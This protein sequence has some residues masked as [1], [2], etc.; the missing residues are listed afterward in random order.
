[1]SLRRINFRQNTFVNACAALVFIFAV[2][3]VAAV[4]PA[5]AQNVEAVQVQ[6]ASWFT[7]R[8]G[9][10]WG[11]ERPMA[12]RCGARMDHVVERMDDHA[13]DEVT[14]T[15]AEETAWLGLLEAVRQS[16]A[17][18]QVFCSKLDE[19]RTDDEASAPARLALAEE[20]VMVGLKML[21]TIRPAFDSFYAAL[22][23]EKRQKL[24]DLV[25]HRHG[26]WH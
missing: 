26:G 2:S 22:D 5:T 4:A 19:A 18:L 11:E 13:R 8:H 15:Q 20:G 12:D 6:N 23:S 24:D 3:G 16:G 14:F 17:A 7:G 10:W 21:Q 9:G 1:M 25:N